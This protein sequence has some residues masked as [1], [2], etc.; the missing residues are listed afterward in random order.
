MFSLSSFKIFNCTQEL[1]VSLTLIPNATL[2]EE[3]SLYLVKDDLKRP[4][5][6][7][8]IAS[9]LLLTYSQVSRDL[10]T[11]IQSGLGG[12]PTFLALRSIDVDEDKT[13]KLHIIDEDEFFDP[14]YDY[15]FTHLEDTET[16]HRGGE[17]YER[18]CGW[19]RFALK[20]NML[21]FF[22]FL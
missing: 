11:Q 20:V 17:V 7:F 15:D 14:G 8:E 19:N 22:V 5:M 3:C 10:F 13:G 18:P 2:H 6:C 21:L 16:Y 4:L 9:L 12:L 1:V